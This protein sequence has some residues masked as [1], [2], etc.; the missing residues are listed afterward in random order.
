MVVCLAS[1]FGNRA[2]MLLTWIKDLKDAKHCP[3]ARL[4]YKLPGETEP[5]YRVESEIALG[6]I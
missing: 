1:L 6:V 3:N 4:L 5:Q 2:E